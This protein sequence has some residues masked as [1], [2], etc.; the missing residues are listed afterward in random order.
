[1]RRQYFYLPAF[2]MFLFFALGPA[3]SLAAAFDPASMRVVISI[4]KF[5]P[6][7]NRSYF[8]LFLYSGDGKMIRQL[9]S[10]SG[11][12]DTNPVFSPDGKQVVFERA[13]PGSKNI[14]TVFFY[15]I[16]DLSNPKPVI[17]PGD[18]ALTR[19]YRAEIARNEKRA[20]WV[21][22][23]SITSGSAETLIYHSSNRE[24]TIERHHNWPS[25]KNLKTDY[26]YDDTSSTTIFW[27]RDTATSTTQ[28]LSTFSGFMSLQGVNDDTP[29]LIRPPLRVAFLQ[30]HRTSTDGTMHFA[31]DLNQ[32]RFVEIAHNAAEIFPLPNHLP[33]FLCLCDEWYQNIGNGHTSANCRYLDL[34]SPEL[35]RTRLGPP[36]SL[37]GG[38]TIQIPNQAPQSI[39]RRKRVL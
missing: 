35:K 26:G 29:F 14:A 22:P 24:Y 31:L 18:D 28:R 3:H 13:L 19:Y 23:E 16:D 20:E 6:D 17:L 32:R 33:A 8:H 12:D 2:V 39:M 4:R 7:E 9:T 38:A 25:E 34:W 5:T 21:K 1:M 15:R 10:T 37:F 36:I 27:L 30:Y 11:A